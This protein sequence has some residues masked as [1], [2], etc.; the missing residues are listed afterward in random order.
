MSSGSTLVLTTYIMQTMKYLFFL[1]H[2]PWIT[3]IIKFAIFGKIAFTFEKKLVIMNGFFWVFHVNVFILK[4]KG[5]NVQIFTSLV[6]GPIFFLKK[7]SVSFGNA[8][9]IF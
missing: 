4:M 7:G 1:N 9:V 6:P 2:L 3:K 8:C 5:L